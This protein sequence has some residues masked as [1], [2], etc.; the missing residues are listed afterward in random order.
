ML[1]RYSTPE[2][3]RVWSDEFK[4]MQWREIEAIAAYVME[5]HKIIPEGVAAKVYKINDFKE[6]LQECQE[7]EKTTQHD[8]VA[9]LNVLERRVGEL[10]KY[11]HYGLT[12]SDLVDTGLARQMVKSLNIVL[13][14]TAELCRAT[15]SLAIEHKHT[16]MMGRT[17]GM[18]AEPTTFGLV[19]LNFH[20]EFVRHV[21][22]LDYVCTRAAVGKMSGAVGTYAHIPPTVEQEAMADIFLEPDKI[23]NQVISRDRHAD[24]RRGDLCTRHAGHISGTPGSPDPSS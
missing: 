15:H 10:G 22:K 7:E 18:Y 6:L 16:Y 8:V 17:H 24:E 2:M 13:E 1:A 5:G 9:F 23:S 14:A 20:N 3:D 21:Q 19:M 4:I 11:I 12:S